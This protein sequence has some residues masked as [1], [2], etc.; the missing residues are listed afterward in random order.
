MFNRT[1]LL[2]LGAISIAWIGYM[3]VNLIS[4]AVAPYPANVFT[5]ADTSVIVI[6]HPEEVD[7]DNPQL[8]VIQDNP[9][10]QQLL[11][12]TERVQHFY[13]SGNR[14]L[15]V[16][17]RSKPWTIKNMER[18]FDE[19]GYSVRFDN[20]K[21]FKLSNG[22]KG[23]Y[24][25][26][27]LLL[28]ES[29]WDEQADKSIN[30]KFVDR[31]SSASI[32]H[33]TGVSFSI[34]N[35]YFIDK[36]NVKYIS[37][38]NSKALPLVNDQEVFQEFIPANFTA[39][40]FYET[41]LLQQL[42]PSKNP[43][44]EWL[45]YG[46]AI[47][48]M[49]AEKCIVTDFK[50]GQDPIAI[51]SSFIDETSGYATEKNAQ[52]HNCSLPKELNIGKDWE[53]EIFNNVALIAKDKSAIDKIIGAYE[54]GNSLAQ[55]N[56]RRDN[57]FSSTPKKVSYRS[58]TAEQH[59][60]KSYLTNSIHTVEEN[61]LT[62]DE[63]Q[64]ENKDVV[65]QLN[66]I[67]LDASVNAIIPIQGSQFV[68]ATTSSNTVYYLNSSAIVWS[69]SVSGQIIGSPFILPN[70]GQLVVTAS[71]GISIFNKDGSLQNGAPIPLSNTLSTAELITWKGQY[72]LAV[73]A[74]NS[75][76][77]YATNGKKIASTNCSIA[78]GQDI[79]LAIQSKKGE[80]IGH[81]IQNGVWSTYNINRKRVLKNQ[82][83]GEGKWFFVK[84]ANTIAAV[85]M[86]QRKFIRVT[87]NGRSSVLVGNI[88]NVIRQVQKEEDALFFV[89]QQQRIY[90]ISNT[91]EIVTQFDT[92][93]R[94]IEDAYLAKLSSGKTLV[95]LVDGISNN[96]YLYSLNG[97]DLGKQQFEGSKKIAL[98]EQSDGQLVLIS[99][100]N[101]YLIRYVVY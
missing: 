97:N 17:E 48:E 74:N 1:F 88:S 37:I 77:V 39:Y 52:I 19:F 23:K 32:L 33:N 2:F 98:H 91:G 68:Y 29:D 6:H 22:W 78:S 10:F 100:A 30:W 80:L 34:E 41:T 85:G 67:R 5:L 86:N 18:Y 93:V 27:Y 73:V 13:F 28:S 7:L 90:V 63:K 14:K 36:N 51:L 69:N 53:I 55:A 99:Q 58:I 50:N 79:A 45:R 75:L 89:Y 4:S 31:K 57:V 47:I 25:D 12:K 20:A 43:M 16:L 15:V 44:Y 56:L 76:A 70:S 59:V 35:S 11:S 49:D 87:E 26:N 64:A 72:H 96:S 38:T 83:I 71:D 9:F 54:T 21:S 94:R 24:T 95:S 92:R 60:T 82:Q 3:G 61:Y 8:Q 65:K 62:S 81:V 84:S 101:N 42:S 66:P 46:V 40:T